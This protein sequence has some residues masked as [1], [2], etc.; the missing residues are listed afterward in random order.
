[1]SPNVKTM[2]SMFFVKAPGKPGQVTS[3]VP[4]LA[5]VDPPGLGWR[6]GIRTSSTSPPAT[7]ASWA[8]G[9]PSTTLLWT[10]GPSRLATSDP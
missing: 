5:C 3:R 10:M 4:V 7:A 1:V 2:Q 8:A 6:R 9:L